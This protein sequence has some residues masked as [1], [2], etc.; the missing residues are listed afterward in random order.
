MLQ[1]VL[2]REVMDSVTDVHEYD[3]MDHNEVNRQFV[4]D[5]LAVGPISGK[6][7]DVGTGTAQI[8]IL[9]YQQ[10]EGIKLR[11]VDLSPDMLDVARANIVLAD[12]MESI[13]LAVEDSKSLPHQDDT[14]DVVISNSLI[15]HLADPAA[16]LR[17][18]VR[19]LRPGGLLFVRDLVRPEDESAL[20]ELVDRY[21]AEASPRAASLFADSLRAA[22]SLEEIQ[23]LVAE[24]GFGRDTIQQSSDRHWTLT[25]R[26]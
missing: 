6:V 2:E 24:L 10:S 20:E 11:A 13:V 4:D 14:F 7:L 19:V 16:A 1:R 22:L 9:L 25:L 18:A 26:K 8:P 17:E 5:L 21:T 15:H 3:A 23:D 12:L